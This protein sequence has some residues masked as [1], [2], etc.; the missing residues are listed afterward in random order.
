MFTLK[1][2]NFDFF[3]MIGVTGHEMTTCGRPKSIIGTAHFIS[4]HRAFHTN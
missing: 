2:I 1:D 4:K 3:S